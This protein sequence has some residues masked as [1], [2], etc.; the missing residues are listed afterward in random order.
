MSNQ[1][2]LKMKED[3]EFMFFL[4]HVWSPDSLFS[5]N[6]V[7]QCGRRMFLETKIFNYF[8]KLF[9]MAKFY[10]VITP[11]DDDNLIKSF[12]K[13]SVSQQVYGFE[14]QKHVSWNFLSR[15]KESHLR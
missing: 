15:S 10:L 4:D 14:I 9:P 12:V 3:T 2:Y 1:D 7:S 6:N 11:D 13:L 8:M 5:W